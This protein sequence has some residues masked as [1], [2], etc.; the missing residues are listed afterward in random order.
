MNSMV[1]HFMKSTLHA[2]SKALDGYCALHRLLI[3]FAEEYP[4]LVNHVNL[5]IADFVRDERCR[6]KNVIPAL[7]EW[8]P[9]ISVSKFT[10]NDVKEAYINESLIRNVRWAAQAEPALGLDKPDPVLDPQRPE[11]T[12]RHNQVSFRLLIY[13]VH[14][15]EMIARPAGCSLAQVASE[16]DQRLGRPSAAQKEEFQA[17]VKDVL[18]SVVSFDELFRR[19]GLKPLPHADLVLLL[20]NAVHISLKRNYHG[21]STSGDKNSSPRGK[22]EAGGNNNHNNN[23]NSNNNSPR[24]GRFNNR[25]TS[26]G[27]MNAAQGGGSRQQLTR[28]LPSSPAMSPLPSPAPSPPPPPVNPW[29][30]RAISRQLSMSA[31]LSDPTSGAYTQ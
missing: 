31:H 17:L 1:V 21:G 29:T 9:L 3:S 2:S 22:K 4:A 27:N 23:N 24:P 8:L 14:F 19:V 6:M 15:L 20:R 12:F 28:S 10:W 30:A 25:K 26:V 16:Y 7:G 5:L 11:R 13:H 18:E